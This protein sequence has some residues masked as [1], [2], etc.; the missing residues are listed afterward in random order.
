[1]AFFYFCG[2]VLYPPADQPLAAGHCEARAIDEYIEIKTVIDGDTVV[3]QGDRT[4][5]LVGID[6]PEFDYET[7]QSEPLAPEAKQLLISL[8]GIS[9][10]V[11]LVYD[12]EKID[13]YGRTLAHLFLQDG[14]NIQ[15]QILGAGLAVPF[16][17]RPNLLFTSCYYEA[18]AR[19]RDAALGLWVLAPFEPVSAAKM[20]GIPPGYRVISGQIDR[21]FDSKQSLTLV[22]DNRVYVVVPHDVLNILNSTDINGLLHNQIQVHGYV[23]RRGQNY[24]LHIHHPSQIRLK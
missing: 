5:R 21:I 24:G 11:G 13:Q 8:L 9:S 16:S 20:M 1:M 6:T 22:L 19:A 15:E 17:V 2:A 7:G 12:N 10:Q 23:F 18:V 14:T 4:I 3:T